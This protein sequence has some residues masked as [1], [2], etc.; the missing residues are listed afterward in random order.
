MPIVTKNRFFGEGLPHTGEDNPITALLA[1]RNDIRV[2]RLKSNYGEEPMRA[3]KI[4]GDFDVIS[5]IIKAADRQVFIDNEGFMK[6][7]NIRPTD[8]LILD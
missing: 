3:A 7:H 8:Y 6:A 4:A 5:Q 2:Q 1:H